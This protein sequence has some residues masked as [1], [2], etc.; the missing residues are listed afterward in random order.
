MKKDKTTLKINFDSSEAAEHF[1]SWLCNAGEQ[2][3]WDWMKYREQ[4]EDGKITALRFIYHKNNEF[5]P[6]FEINTK[7]GRMDKH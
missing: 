2:D 7:C 3:Y 1:A 6:D 4:E 5:I